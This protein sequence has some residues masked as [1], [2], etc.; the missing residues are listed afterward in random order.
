MQLYDWLRGNITACERQLF[1]F[2]EVD[3]MPSGVLNSIKPLIDYRDVV[4]GADYTQCIF[5]FLSNTGSDLINEQYEDYWRQGRQRESLQLKDFEKLI[6]TGAFNEKGDANCLY[7]I[8]T[9][10]ELILYIGPIKSS[11]TAKCCLGKWRASFN[12][13]PFSYRWFLSKRHYQE[14]PD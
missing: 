9:R 6:S 13:R 11:R 1:I 14:Q 2:D 7:T 8:K 5:I 4:D 3:K 10:L 12:S